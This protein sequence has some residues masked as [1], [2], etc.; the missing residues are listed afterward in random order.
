MNLLSLMGATLAA[1]HDLWTIIINWIQSTVSNYGWTII[2]F[3]LLVKVATLPLD[4]MVKLTSKKQTLVQKKC[5]PDV[6]KLKKKFGND[7]KTLQVQTNA[8]YKR[9]GLKQG[10]GCLIML[11]NLV[12]TMVIFFTLYS[13]LK[14]VSAYEAIKQYETLNTTYTTEFCTTLKNK[15]G[16]D[17]NTKDDAE[18]WMLKLDENDEH[19]DAENYE[20]NYAYAQEATKNAKKAVGTKWEEIK[21]SWL[22][23]ENIWVADATTSPFPTYSA[24]QGISSNKDIKNYIQ[25]N[26]NEDDYK[27]ISAIVASEGSRTLNG[28]Y[29][30]AILIGLSTFASQ[31][32][33]DLHNK[34]KSKKANTLTKI[35]EQN[36]GAAVGGST[37]KIMKIVLPI[38][39]VIFALTSASSFSIYMLAS[40]VISLGFGE[41]TSLVVDALT[42]KQRLEVEEA[43][44]KEANR[45]IKKGKIKG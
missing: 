10:T 43:L 17:I 41:I 39:M 36:G 4:F 16:E 13:S 38:I 45:L 27:T 23:I 19:Y 11:V 18:N 25:N 7:Q 30:L 24:L 35:S 29:I 20:T 37:M 14:N 9:E 15:T 3:T 28:Y 40:S 34:F 6:A 22:W 42:K 32:V 1:P 44:E 21:D 26:I 2:L 12:L 33:A 5:A 8:L 31:F